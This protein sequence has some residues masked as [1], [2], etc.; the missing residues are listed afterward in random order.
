MLWCDASVNLIYRYIYILVSIY[1][2]IYEFVCIHFCIIYNKSFLRL[3]IKRTMSL[4]R[5]AVPAVCGLKASDIR[6]AGGKGLSEVTT[7]ILLINIQ[8]FRLCNEMCAIILLT[9]SFVSI[10]FHGE[11]AK[12]RYV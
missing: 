7:A 11:L 10:Q 5:V 12:F 4:I 6:M 8:Y 3:W 1:I 9:S 2:L